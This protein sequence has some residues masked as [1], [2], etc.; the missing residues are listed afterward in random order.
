MSPDEDGEGSDDPP[1]P[2]EARI[3]ALED[4]RQSLKHSFS[5]LNDY[6]RRGWRVMKFNGIVATVFIALLPTQKDVFSIHPHALLVLGIGLF[7]L[8]I[9]T[10]IGYYVQK[11]EDVG[12]GPKHE[13][14]QKISDWNYGEDQYL[15]W[16]LEKHAESI[17]ILIDVN[18]AKNTQLKFGIFTSVMGV[19]FLITGS[20]Y[21]LVL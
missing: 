21:A 19:G 7:L 9:S 13:T 10:A 20:I 16:S 12:I 2:I 14:Y 18:N 8:V 6:R 5:S 17:N 11:A 3:H 4:A 15:R 1:D